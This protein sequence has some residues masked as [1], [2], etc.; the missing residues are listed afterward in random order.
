MLGL[1]PSIQ[2]ISTRSAF[3]A[4]KEHRAWPQEGEPAPA[5]GRGRGPKA[6]AEAAV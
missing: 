3:G 1:D 4:G 5:K 6:K 2:G